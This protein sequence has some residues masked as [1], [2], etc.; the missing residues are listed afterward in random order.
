MRFTEEI[1]LEKVN[2][3]INLTKTKIIINIDE[4]AYIF[5]ENN[6]LGKKCFEDNKFQ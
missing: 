6:N 5:I 2:L 1:D 3:L 4:S